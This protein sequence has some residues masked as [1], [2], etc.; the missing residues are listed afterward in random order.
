MPLWKSSWYL[1]IHETQQKTS[2]D[3]QSIV[4]HIFSLF[5]QTPEYKKNDFEYKKTQ[6]VIE[7]ITNKLKKTMWYYDSDIV[8]KK[9][10]H[11]I[12]P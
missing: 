7:D 9:L 6:A 11:T 5:A 12:K 3:T 8:Q 4:R 10:S 1:D 2:G